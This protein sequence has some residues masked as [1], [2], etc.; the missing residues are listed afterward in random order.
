RIDAVQLPEVDAL[1]AEAP[2][3]PLH[4]PAQVVG[5]AVRHP[6]IGTRALEPALGRN[7]EAVI[8]MQG[9]A[10]QLFADGRAVAVGGIDEVDA[11]IGQA[12]QRT[13]R[14][15]AVGRLAPD[16]GACHPHGAEAQ[17]VDLDVA[18]DLEAAGRCRSLFLH[19]ELSG[20]SP[21]MRR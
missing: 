9:F 7:E 12:A 8:G 1:D 6:L 21:T 16:T 18:A 10:D 20:K 14:L 17:P 3:A 13:E 11:E 2:Q 15:G 5:P 4:A 19:Y